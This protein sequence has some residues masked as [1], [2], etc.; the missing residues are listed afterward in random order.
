MDKLETVYAE[1]SDVLE[2]MEQKS[3]FTGCGT[4]DAASLKSRIVELKD[5]IKMERNDYMVSF[6]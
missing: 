4:A 2:G 5:Q 1:I 3:S 6:L